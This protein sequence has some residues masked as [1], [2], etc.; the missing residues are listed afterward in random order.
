MYT[1]QA[2]WSAAR[3][4]INA[5]IIICNNGSYRL[6]QLN[7]AAYWKERD[8]PA[9]DFP[10]S[11]DLSHP[12]L[13]FVDIARGMGVAGVRVEKPWEIGPAITQMLAHPGP[14]L[15]DLVLAGD[16]HPERVGNTCGQ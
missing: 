7:I 14:F 13:N 4:N 3:H 15:I 5:K 9:H 8:I 11:F 12:P 16:T 1:I 6:L 10:L 2:L